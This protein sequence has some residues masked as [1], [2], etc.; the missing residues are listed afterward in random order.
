MELSGVIHFLGDLLGQVIEQVESAEGFSL[1]ERVRGLA[2]RRRAGEGSGS[3]LSATINELDAN[4]AR[5]VAAAFAVYFDLVNL[6]EDANR[7][8][9]L[10]DR[11]RLAGAEPSE[12]SIGF[13]LKC[14]RD[15]GVPP[16]AVESVLANLRIEVVLTSHPTEVKRRTVL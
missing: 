11:E 6:A 7:V 15:D 5:V 2:K 14:A 13:A 12:G 1:E 8:R 16:S 9:V 3:E 10:R 4:A